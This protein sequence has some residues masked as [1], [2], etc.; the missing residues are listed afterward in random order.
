MKQNNYGI[1]K[2]DIE[3]K[4]Y[5]QHEETGMI[6]SKVFSL[7]ELAE[8]RISKWIRNVIPRHYFIGKVESTGLKDKNGKKI[9]EGDILKGKNKFINAEVKFIRGA[10][11]TLVG[12]A[13]RHLEGRDNVEVI[14]NIFENPELIPETK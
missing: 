4:Y 14:G 6:F 9:F 8:L 7:V 1:G 5:F 12:L 11:R 3:F 2:R 13:S 10:F